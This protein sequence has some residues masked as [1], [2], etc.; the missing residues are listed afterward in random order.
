M[1]WT[2]ILW[3]GEQQSSLSLC[4]S[5]VWL[6][7]GI[8]CG[9]ESLIFNNRAVNTQDGF[10]ANLINITSVL[11]EFLYL[12]LNLVYS[13]GV[14]PMS[15]HACGSSAY[16]C[17]VW[18][19]I[20]LIWKSP[21]KYKDPGLVVGLVT[22]TSSFLRKKKKLMNVKSRFHTGPNPTSNVSYEGTGGR[23]IKFQLWRWLTGRS[24]GEEGIW[25]GGE[26]GGEDNAFKFLWP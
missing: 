11:K 17:F 26:F 5:S 8:C 22:L 20:I 3:G 16:S 14:T 12:D 24:K 4:K 23:E 21:V 10:S 18:V 2:R 19:F 7:T 25:S 13:C 6:F 15:V 1:Q 9:E